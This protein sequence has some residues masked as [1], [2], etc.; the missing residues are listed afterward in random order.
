MLDHDDL[1]TPGFELNTAYMVILSSNIFALLSHEDRTEAR[2]MKFQ[3]F[4]NNWQML[5]KYPVE[6]DQIF[7]CPSSQAPNHEWQDFVSVVYNKAIQFPELESNQ[8]W[9]PDE[10]SS[11]LMKYLDANRFFWDCLQVAQGEGREMIEDMIMKAPEGE[12]K[13]SDSHFCEA[14]PKRS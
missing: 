7:T 1:E 9:M 2:V 11:A 12:Q 14:S 4:L 10:Y 5:P 13:P 6:N 3:V 8:S